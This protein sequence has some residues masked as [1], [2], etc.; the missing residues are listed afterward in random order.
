MTFKSLYEWAIPPVKYEV[1]MSSARAVRDLYE[2]NFTRLRARRQP[3]FCPPWKQAAVLGWRIL[4]PIT[5]NISPVEQ[6]EISSHNDPIHI[7]KTLG[8]NQ[9]WTRHDATIAL[10]SP[11]WLNAFEFLTPS[12]PQ[13]M[14][15][16]NGM[17]TVE[18]RM[19]W[20]AEMP[21]DFGLLI[22]PSPS[23]IN[24]GVEIGFLSN[25]ILHKIGDKGVS[26]A[27]KPQRKVNISRG[28]EIARIIPIS[29]ECL[30][31]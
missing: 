24:L 3:E 14:F 12:G 27:I 20:K 29:K 15:I 30:S 31:I 2:Q 10:T 8:M 23:C 7:A 18:W 16:P 26:I 17:S 21:K 5:V 4:S 19:G 11:S 13:N 6:T 25:S 9:V 28:D 1:N 22:I